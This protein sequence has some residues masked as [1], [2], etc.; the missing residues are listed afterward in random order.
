ML[1][2]LAAAKFWG[3]AAFRE[4]NYGNMFV[5]NLVIAVSSFQANTRL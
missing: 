5:L 1:I 3:I 2:T 4:G